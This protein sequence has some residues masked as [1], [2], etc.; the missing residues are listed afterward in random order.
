MGRSLILSLNFNQPLEIYIH[1]KMVGSGRVECKM[2]RVNKESKSYFLA[3]GPSLLA[4]I[5]SMAPSLS[6]VEHIFLY[7]SPCFDHI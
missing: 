4:F 2:C 7:V 1:T 5:L 6:F 3:I